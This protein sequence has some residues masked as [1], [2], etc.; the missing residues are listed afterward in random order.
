MQSDVQLRLAGLRHY[1]IG[2]ILCRIDDND[3]SGKR[4]QAV[5]MPA[6]DTRRVLRLLPIDAY[7][8]CIQDWQPGMD[9]NCSI[10]ILVF[11]LLPYQHSVTFPI[12]Q[13]AKITVKQL[14]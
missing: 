3:I 7:A 8:W 4:R 6:Y 10:G 14:H 12:F 2:D 1:V 13:N 11:V 9:W 5:E